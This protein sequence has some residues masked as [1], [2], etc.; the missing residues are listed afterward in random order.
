MQRVSMKPIAAAAA[1]TALLAGCA[2]SWD[3]GP[4]Y[5]RYDSHVIGTGPDTGTA[6]VTTQPATVVTPGVVAPAVVYTE[7]SATVVTPG[8]DAPA[9]SLVPQPASPPSSAPPVT[10]T[11][12]SATYSPGA[13]VI[14]PGPTVYRERSTTVTQPNG[15]VTTYRQPVE[16]YQAPDTVWDFGPSYTD[17]AHGQWRCARACER[18]PR[19]R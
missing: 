17:R 13:A 2:T 10:D 14:K 16:V 12:P 11:T 8:A 15:T 19:T 4:G 5:Y 3:V 9:P 1:V 7:P 6:V 18:P